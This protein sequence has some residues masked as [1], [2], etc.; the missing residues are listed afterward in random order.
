M[1][2]PVRSESKVL[3]LGPG[4]GAI[5]R[6]IA[7]KLA[8]TNQLTMIE[9]EPDLAGLCQSKY[10]PAKVI[11]G[12][13][14][15]VLNKNKETFDFILSGVPFAIMAKDKRQ[16]VFKLVNDRLK[17]NGQF[18]MFQYSLTTLNELREIFAAVDIKFT[19]WNIPPAVAYF[20]HKK[21]P[22]V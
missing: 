5:T 15:D 22:T 21:S 7:D 12:D 17:P 1:T 10:P 11:L 6:F 20:C 14:E 13:V 9:I 18:I 2:E 19:P 4:N 8:D 3:E 16:R